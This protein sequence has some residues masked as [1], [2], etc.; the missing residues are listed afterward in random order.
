MAAL[1]PSPDL[2]TSKP[3]AAELELDSEI[4]RRQTETPEIHRRASRQVYLSEWNSARAQTPGGSV[5][6]TFNLLTS[7]WHAFVQVQVSTIP[8][9]SRG[10]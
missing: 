7:S 8:W 4:Q 3:L 10:C 1:Q 2:L 6:H 9:S 5:I